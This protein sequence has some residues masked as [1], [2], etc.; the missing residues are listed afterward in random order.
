LC[1]RYLRRLASTAF[2][3]LA[4]GFVGHSVWAA[5]GIA[6]D[7]ASSGVVTPGTS[8]TYGLTVT[9]TANRI[10][11]VNVKT[12]TTS[13]SSVTYNGSNL[14]VIG[15]T[16]ET[17]NN[18]YDFLYYMVA[19][20][21]GTHD[22]VVTLPSST[23]A[24][25]TAASYTGASQSNQPD[26][27]TTSNGTASGGTYSVSL[28]TGADNSWVVMGAAN[29][30][31]IVTGVGSDTTQRA[32]DAQ[33]AEELVDSNGPISPAGSRTLNVTGQG[34]GDHWAAVMASFKP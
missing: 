5:G 13:V 24:H 8:I 10:L 23:Y 3:M 25:S 29:G 15:S 12:F 1:M 30:N 28:T 6:F 2:I 16:H 19:P 21:A 22:V 26:A 34:S 20:D 4:L 18:T 17:Y 27:Y 32:I 11:F 9:S 7:N 14:T 33:T 31:T